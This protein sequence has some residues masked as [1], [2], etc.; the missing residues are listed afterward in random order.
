MLKSKF[1]DGLTMQSIKEFIRVNYLKNRTIV[2]RDLPGIFDDIEKLTSLPVIRHKYH[3]GEEYGTWLIPPQWDVKEAWLKDDKGNLIASYEDHPLFVSP[4]SKSVHTT[5]SKEEL[6]AHTISEPRQPDAFAYNWRYAYDPKLQLKSWGI[7]LP[8][9]LVNKLGKGPFEVKIDVTVSDGNM[10]VGEMVLP[11]KTEDTIVFLADYCHPGQVNDSFSGL[12]MFMKVMHTLSQLSNRRYTYKF[13][14]FP[15]TI[16]SAVYIASDPSRLRNVKGAV[17]SE[18]VGWGREWYIKATRGGNTYLDLL[19]AECRRAFPETKSSNFFSLFG[20]DEYIFN[21]VQV[22]IPTLSLQKYP[23]E[24]YHT[25]NDEPSLLVDAN[26]Q[27][28]VDI[29]LHLVDVVERD[30]IFK[31]TN[32]VP[33]WMSRFDLF[34]DVI[35]EP[36]DFQ[37]NF[38][39][40]YQYLDGNNS[41]LKIAEL[42]NCSF[43]NIYSYIK[44]MHK[45]NLIHS[46]DKSPWEMKC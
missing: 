1:L 9:N 46:T 37:R 30:E 39:I 15:E 36:E 21:S 12:V 29:I 14:M 13:L 32:P 6:L 19:A 4:Y 35:Y 20:N 33:F 38:N 27:Y 11:G 8:L 22:N 5:L 41:I 3:T 45:N 10:I 28:A 23:Y 25:S 31:F 2:S 26:I 7:S 18:M 17:F 16:G 34:A 42:L 24:E 43:D 44:K 40:V